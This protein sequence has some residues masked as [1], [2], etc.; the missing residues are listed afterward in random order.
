MQRSIPDVDGV[1]ADHGLR[2]F[3]FASGELQAHERLPAWCEVV[4][5][6]AR[7]DLSPASAKAFAVQMTMHWLGCAASDGPPSGPGACVLRMAATHGGAATRGREYLSDGNDDVVL[8][9]QCAGNRLV[10]QRG[11]Q[12]VL[13]PGSALLSSNADV[14]LI[15]MQESARFISIGVPRAL[16][17]THAPALED[18]FMRPLSPDTG[19]LRLL[20]AYVGVLD[21][22][23]ALASAE[24][25]HAVAAHID[26][27]CALA[28]GA[29]RDAAEIAAGRGL[30]AARLRA[31]KADIAQH[32]SDAALGPVPLAQRQGITPRYL[33]KLFE[34]EGTTLSRYVL[35][36]RLAAVHRMLSDPR[37]AALRIGTIAYD[38][39]FNDLSTFNREF[40]RRFGA[41]PSDVRQAIRRAIRSGSGGCGSP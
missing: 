28:V 23:A 3:R 34:R 39:G 38:N 10:Q 8:H 12:V 20:A 2:A 4:N 22:E 18:T 6:V 13:G 30:Q 16:L 27:L 17:L 26:D 15:S 7:R 5:R 9:I 29:T 11:R 33:H 1:S 36:L 24:L 25:R 40:R 21:D 41:T 32:L 14:S 19:V 31:V 37:H 35:G